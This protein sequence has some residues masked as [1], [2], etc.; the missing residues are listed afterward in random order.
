[1]DEKVRKEEHV[2]CLNCLERFYVK[3]GVQK[4]T[5]PG[6]QMEWRMSWHEDG[7]AKIRG[8]VW[9]KVKKS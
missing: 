4:A 2:R 5:C 8:P 3:R 1:M 7:M 6:C 9:E